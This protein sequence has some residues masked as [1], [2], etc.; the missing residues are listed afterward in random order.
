[1]LINNLLLKNYRNYNDLEIKFSKG[2][3][4]FIGDNAQGKTNI[5]EAIYVLAITKSYLGVNDKDLI[6][7][8][9]SCAIIKANALVDDF[10]TNLEVKINSKGKSVFINGKE[11]KKF[12]DY[13]SKLN[14][15]IFSP[16]NIR[17]IKDG[18]NARRKFLNVEIS[19]ILNKYVILM[20]DFNCLLKQR[21]ELLKSDNIN[22]IYMDIINEKFV[23]LAISICLERKKFLDSI[24]LKIGNIFEDISGISGLNIRYDCSLDLNADAE[25]SKVN[26]LFKI[27]D[28]FEKERKYGSSLYGPHRD[29]FSFFIGDKNISLYG[30]QGQMRMAILSLKLAEIEVFKQ[31]TNS[32]PI[33]L[34][35]DIFSELDITKRN[36]LIKY[37]SFDVQT[38]I[39]TT[40][41]NMINDKLLGDAYIFKIAEGK[42][43]EGSEE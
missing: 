32:Y 4:I 21:N 12:K 11:I 25:T 1:M 24:N 6:K 7:F 9:D 10:Y 28:S 29:D 40:D 35:D 22:T 16:D 23:S 17:M 15:I 31:Y 41:L 13:V 38:I 34:L 2:L 36:N 19:Q 42:I 5:L 43:I 26:V 20:N 37:I 33:L 30:S 8:G 18:P 3:N 27:R 39:T 14:V